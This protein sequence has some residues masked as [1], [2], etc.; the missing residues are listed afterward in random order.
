[1]SIDSIFELILRN[2]GIRWLAIAFV[3]LLIGLYISFM[4]LVLLAFVSFGIG[5]YTYFLTPE[6]P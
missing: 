1:M 6:S 2:V 4:P 3:L 5:V